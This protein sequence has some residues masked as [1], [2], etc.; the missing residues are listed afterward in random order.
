MD[1]TE[2][3]KEQWDEVYGWAVTNGYSFEDGVLGKGANHPVHTLTWWDAVKWCNAR[4][5]KEGRVPAYYTNAALTGV[6]RTGQVNVQN[7]WVRW[8]GGYR[9]PTEA[10]WEKAARGGVAG[11]RFGFGN[12]ITHGQANY[13]SST[14]YAYDVSPTRGLHPTYNN[15]V[16]PYTS[17]VGSF[18]TNGYG[19]YDM[20]GNV[21][22]WCWDWYGST[23]YSSSPGA[24]PRGPASGSIRMM[25]GG[26]WNYI[27][28][29]ARSAHRY[30]YTPGA[31]FFD[32]GFRAVLSPGQ[33]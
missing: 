19:L 8:T 5:E 23:Y 14:S 24:D 26:S 27:A 20:V 32:C 29:D 3:T 28:F 21:W 15:G 12:T 9:L 18:G 16:S 1:R 30:G 22:E 11:Q 4:S 6:Y 2:V 13:S 31:R 10:E 17:P 25:R 7:D 33:P